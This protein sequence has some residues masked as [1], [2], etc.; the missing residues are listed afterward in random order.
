[1][2]VA[3][4]AI[5][6]GLRRDGNDLYW[7]EDRPEEDGRQALV[8]RGQGG[9]LEEVAPPGVNVRTRVHEYGGGAFTVRDGIVVYA[10]LADGRLFRIDDG[11][12]TPRPLTPPGPVRYGDLTIDPTGR[13]ITCVREDHAGLEHAPRGDGRA[14]EPTNELVAVPLDGGEPLVLATGNDFYAAPRVSPDGTRLAWLTWNHPDMPWD[15]TELWV[16]RLGDDGVVTGAERVAGGPAESVAE[17]VW[18]GEGVLH[19]VADGSGWWRLHRLVDGRVEALTALEAE[20]TDPAWT[21]GGHSYGIA[22]DGSIVCAFR[23]GGHDHL[24][25]IAAGTSVLDRYDLPFTEIDSVHV[26]PDDVVFIGG[27]P[28]RPESVIRLDPTDG[29]WEVVHEAAPLGIDPGFISRSTLVTFPTEDGRTGHAHLYPP[30]S[31][32]HEAP[33]GE[34][35]PLIVSTHGGPTAAAWTGFVPWIQFFTSRGFAVLDVDYGGSTGYGRDYR[36]RLEGG[37]GIV[38]VDDVVSAARHVVELGGADP[39]RLAIRGGSA[40]GYTT[41]AAL[42][43]RDLFRAGVSYYGIG[44]LAAL[45]RDTHKFE[46]RYEERLVGPYPES[47]EIY[48][49]RSPALHPD[50]FDAPLLILQ[51]LD[52]PVV[53]PAQAEVIVEALRAKGVPYAYLA[54]EGEEHGFRGAEALRRSLEAELSFYARVF[55]FEPADPIEPL[56]IHGLPDRV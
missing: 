11:A 55:A 49:E 23:Q 36:R 37:W 13:W 5:I 38:D 7:L 9:S 19:F 44:D 47:E 6:S 35:P 33:S 51:G 26:G 56:V 41:L 17:P 42:C 28:D 8:H 18:S 16:G 54:F 31:A 21:L 2:T 14:A 39:D 1:M 32:D 48:R 34:R 25:R 24:G 46:S 40:G 10:D 15:S 52:D 45:A 29:R 50:G 30:T 53:P 43:F 12:G 22:P 4:L 20:F 27:A 3:R